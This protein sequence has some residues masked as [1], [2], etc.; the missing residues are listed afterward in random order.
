V[1]S[2]RSFLYCP[3]MAVNRLN[4]PNSTLLYLSALRVSTSLTLFCDP[5]YLCLL[6]PVP[7]C[8]L[9][10]GTLSP[11]TSSCHPSLRTVVD[12]FFCGF[13]ALSQPTVSTLFCL[14]PLVLSVYVTNSFLL[15]S[16]PLRENE[17]HSVGRSEVDIRMKRFSVPFP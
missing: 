8:L 11:S 15:F 4:K 3:S 6:L 12:F 16:F 1:N 13:C 9:R 5:L 2:I 14:L 7:V 10:V 17:R